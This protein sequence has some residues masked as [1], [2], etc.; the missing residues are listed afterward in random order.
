MMISKFRFSCEIFPASENGYSLAAFLVRLSKKG[1]GGGGKTKRGRRGQLSCRPG[2]ILRHDPDK[3][4]VGEIRDPETA[5]IAIQS[6]LTGHLVLTSVHANNVFDVLGRFLHMGVDTYSFVSALNGI[7]AQRLIRLICT[8]CSVP[9]KPTAEELHLSA[10][11]AEQAKEMHFCK[12]RGCGNCRGSGYK[13][14]HAIGEVLNLN[15]E[16][17]ELIISRAP[18]RTIKEAKRLHVRMAQ[19]SCAML[20]LVRQRLVEQRWRKLIVLLSFRNQLTVTLYPTRITI[21]SVNCGWRPKSGKSVVLTF[22]NAESTKPWQGPISILRNWL[23]QNKT[24]GANLQIILANSF[25]K[26]TLIPWPGNFLKTSEQNTFARLHYESLYG[27]QVQNWAFKIAHSDYDQAM[28]CDAFENQILD[29]LHELARVQKLK[30]TSLKLDF[31]CIF[32]RFRHMFSNHALLGVVEPN[33]CV[34]GCFKGGQWQSIRTIKISCLSDEKIMQ[35]LERE[36]VLQGLDETAELYVYPSVELPLTMSLQNC[37][38]TVLG[39]GRIPTKALVGA[40][41][42]A[43]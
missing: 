13:G 31:L 39:D 19:G 25:V 27:A 9:H 33:Q 6:A 22:E 30:F 36:R 8:E 21:V 41:S 20:R 43:A 15:D 1:G 38:V 14:R 12:G 23:E 10:I 34:L 24:T 40:L 37:N 28:I 42:E 29:S 35:I 4:L 3:I 16:L 7:L 26:Y 18:I 2:S 17:R 11:T 32:N 5:Q